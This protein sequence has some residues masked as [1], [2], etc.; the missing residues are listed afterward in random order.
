MVLI[1][2][3]PGLGERVNDPL[4][5]HRVREWHTQLDVF[6]RICAASGEIVDPASDGPSVVVAKLSTGKIIGAYASK[7]WSSTGGWMGDENTF[8]FS[9]TNSF[10]H[11]Y[12]TGISSTYTQ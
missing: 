7:S 12:K 10:K 11:S 3:A 5:H 8:L 4:L 9:L 6:E 1:S 2:G